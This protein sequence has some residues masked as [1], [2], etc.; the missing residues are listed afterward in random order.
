MKMPETLPDFLTDPNAVLKDSVDWRHGQVPDYSAANAKY[1]SERTVLHSQDS[2]EQRVTCLVKNWEKEVSFKQHLKDFRT[3]APGWWVT[4]N[5]G[6]KFTLPDVLEQGSYNALIGE[7][8]FFCSSKLGFEESHRTFRRAM[9]TGFAWEVLD[10]WSGPPKVA[11]K[12]RHWGK[13]TGQLHC[14]L[15]NGMT[16]IAQP[17]M[18]QHGMSG[19][20]LARLD[21][22]FRMESLELYFDQQQPMASMVSDLVRL[23]DSFELAESLPGVS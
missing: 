1:A 4:V 22:D 23:F 2:L 10:V 17:T 19:C 9:P 11:F 6:R 18:E 14:P 16:I 21:A 5:G 13:M 15:S 8:A 3:M 20:A 12:W 7:Q